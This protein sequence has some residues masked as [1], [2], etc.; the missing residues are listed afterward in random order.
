MAN[1]L[2]TG[3]T[4]YLGIPLVKRLHTLGHN[5]KLLIRESS[6]IS[7][8]KGLN[9]IEY[10]IGDV[11]DLES[12]SQASEQVDLI[13]H[14]A[15]YVKIWAKDNSIYDEVNVKGSENIA[16]VALERNIP[17]YYISSF[18]A[19]GPNPPDG[20]GEPCNETFEHIDFF[21]ND[22]ERTKFY[23]R[24]KIRVYMK[25]GLKTII[26]YPGF[27][28]GP[29]DFNIYGEMMFDIIAEQF[30][31]LP[32]KGESIFCM[33]YLDDV[34]EGLVSVIKKDN[35]VGQSFMLGGENISIKDY[36]NLI[37]EIA[38]VKKPRHFPFWSGVLFAR[39]CKLKAKMGSGK[40]IPY[41]T[42]DMIVGMKYNW[43]YSSKTA[44]EKIGYKITPI[45]EALAIT[46]EWYKNFIKTHG[47]NKKKIGI[48]R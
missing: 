47:T 18:G 25:K 17:L 26:F 5:L 10:H 4:G 31:G 28:F 32:G 34:I 38:E 13:Y 2:I 21:Q 46:I 40:K 27:V 12:L 33:A 22:Y 48:R 35:L 11:R 45:R 24:E 42:P 15:G 44:I 20:N 39:M 16:K 1:I 19:L 23:G 8:F 41:I 30:L 7:P 43:A 37:A 3:G 14:L 9:N 36:L 29:G 6:N